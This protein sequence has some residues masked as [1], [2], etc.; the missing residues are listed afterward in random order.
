MIRRILAV[1]ASA[2]LLVTGATSA[3]AHPK[4]PKPTIVLVHGAFA[5]GGSW[6]GV[7]KRLQR[8]GYQVVVP[9]VPLRGI[10][11]DTSYLTGVLAS[12][13]GPKVL[14]G[15][16][17]GGALITELAG[18]A[19]VKS[20]VYVAAFIPQAGETIGALNAKYPG[21]EIGPD[22]TNTITYAAGAD[23]VMK[24]ESFRAVFAADLPAREAAVLGASQ[25]PVAA[26]V[27]GETVARSAPAGL[28]KYALVPS[29]DKAIPPAGE[30][31]M[32][33][34]AGA[35]IVKVQGASHLVM[36]SE[37]GTVT[38]LIEKAAH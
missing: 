34:R 12:I 29:G 8:D 20:L 6:A 22:T 7:T 9:A 15:H 32:A 35:R 19:G 36:I 26:A 3:V 2:A 27:F 23:L 25:R 30:Q 1:A 21:S 5:D 17:Y 38:K 31:F 10:A 18:T 16:S 33:E 14:V 24:P 11:S 37:A 4:D 28:P 13:P